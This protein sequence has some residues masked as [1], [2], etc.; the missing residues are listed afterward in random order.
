MRPYYNFVD[1]ITKMASKE[2]LNNLSVEDLNITLYK[3]LRNQ[4]VDILR[5]V[6]ILM[7]INRDAVNAKSK[8]HVK[9]IIEKIY[10]DVLEDAEK[11]EQDKKTNL[12][13][14]INEVTTIMQ[15]LDNKELNA[16]TSSEQKKDADPDERA[17]ENIKVVNHGNEESDIQA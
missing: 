11:S 1:C 2:S 3:H 10:K 12:I 6:A 17:K 15:K 4:R 8:R 5:I 9:K 16:P 7:G 13:G 14:I